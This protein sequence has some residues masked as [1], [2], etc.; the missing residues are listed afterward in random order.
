MSQLKRILLCIIFFLPALS[1][2]NESTTITSERRIAITFYRL[3][4]LMA[5]LPTGFNAGQG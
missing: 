4:S 2:A 1:I 3:P 5:L